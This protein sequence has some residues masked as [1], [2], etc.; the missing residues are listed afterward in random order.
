M[1][2]P[3]EL[4]EHWKQLIDDYLDGVLD[5]GGMQDLESHLRAQPDARRYFVRYARLHTDLYLEARARDAARR[6]L[7][8]L[9]QMG[10]AASS[11]SDK[12][13]LGREHHRP[14][15]N[16]RAT[17]LRLFTAKRLA[18]AAGLFLAVVTT[19]WLVRGRFRPSRVAEESAIAWLVNAQDC[20]WS[21][22][23]PTG[24]LQSGTVLKI[25]RGLAEIRFQCGAHVILEGPCQAELKSGWC[26]QL[27]SGKLTA[28]VPAEATGFEVESPHGTVVDLGTEFGVR[29]DKGLTEVYVFKG[30]VEAHPHATPNAPA[31]PVTEHHA[32]QITSGA[33]R[34]IPAEDAEGRF[35]RTI[36]PPPVV[37][38]RSLRLTFN[39]AM[40]G[41]IKDRLG[42]GT[43]LTHRL[44]GTGNLFPDRDSNLRLNREKSQLSLL[45]PSKGKVVI[46]SGPVIYLSL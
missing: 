43:G 11:V 3:E 16:Y 32:A 14:G 13:A 12:P 26:T 2:H 33:V 31:Q 17:V 29:S 37:V 45:V 27:V 19:V 10:E 34:P 42:L 30:K 8:R 6:A 46:V 22:S 20:T 1:N 18:I 44:P 40:D 36:M 5:E 25:D 35:V 28:R 21:D 7:E 15:R 39:Q 4:P 24:N 41:T 38:P 9:E 23:G